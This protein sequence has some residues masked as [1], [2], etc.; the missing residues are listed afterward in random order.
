MKIEMHVDRLHIL[1][2][3][4]SLKEK[5]LK[6]IKLNIINRELLNEYYALRKEYLAAYR[7]ERDIRRAEKSACIKEEEENDQK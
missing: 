7:N 6:D 5:A 4:N 2:A 3:I 1:H